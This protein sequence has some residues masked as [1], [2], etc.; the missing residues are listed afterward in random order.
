MYHRESGKPGEPRLV[1]KEFTVNITGQEGRR[2]WGE[3]ASKD[4]TGPLVGV[5]A[6]YKQTIHSVDNAR[7]SHHWQGHGPGRFE[8][9]YRACRKLRR[10]VQ[11]GLGR[12]RFQALLTCGSPKQS[13][14]SRFCSHTVQ[15]PAKPKPLRSPSLAS[16]PW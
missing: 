3:I 9:C 15:P 16:K 7:G 2:F 6:S 11:D 4:D 10:R 5:I 12:P 8:L 14:S 1:N 13:A